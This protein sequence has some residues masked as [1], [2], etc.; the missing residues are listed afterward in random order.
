MRTISKEHQLK[1]IE[2]RRKANELRKQGLLPP[3]VLTE[4]HKAS[5]SRYQTGKVKSAE[6]KAKISNTK[7]S[8]DLRFNAGVKKGHVQ[9]PEHIQKRIERLQYTY[10]TPTGIW[11]GLIEAAEMNDMTISILQHK[12]KHEPELYS[13]VSKGGK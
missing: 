13:I 1:L 4:E 5:I 6:T 9:S 10:Q 7:M 8:S 2:G 3:R 12:L 11:R